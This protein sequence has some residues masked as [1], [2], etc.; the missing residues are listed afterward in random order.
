VRVGS[1]AGS[2]QL[3]RRWRA[4]GLACRGL[5]HT[6]LPR[7][8]R[9]GGA[10]ASTGASPAAST[11]L[12]GDAQPW[13]PPPALRALSANPSTLQVQLFWK[14]ANR[15]VNYKTYIQIETRKKVEL[16]KHL[17]LIMGQTEQ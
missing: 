4:A 10:P 7:P 14:K 3:Q 8:S 5:Q 12:W 15:V 16:D 11:Q 13:R 9:G 2:G 6:H 1:W 17:D